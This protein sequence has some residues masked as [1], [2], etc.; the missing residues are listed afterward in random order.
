MKTTKKFLSL[1]VAVAALCGASAYAADLPVKAPYTA[2]VSLYNWTG[3]YIGADVGGAWASQDVT[4]VACAICNQFPASGTLKGSSLLGGVYAG[5]NFM[6][7]PQFLV[8]IEGDWNFAHLDDT[9]TAPSELTDGTP[10]VAGSSG[11]DW[12]H[13]VKW[14]AS[15][16]G[17]LGWAIMPNALL[18]AT[19]GAAWSKVDYS[20]LDRFG[21]GCPN[22]GGV[23]FSQ[24][25]TGYAV[26][27]GAEWAP[28]NNNWLVRAEYLYYHFAGASASG[29]DQGGTG[30]VAATFDWDDLSIHTARAGLAY[31]F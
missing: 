5:Y 16:R 12:S 1:G 19:G 31:R 13:D 26:G 27:A 20:A 29:I 30:I 4:S 3:F 6:L 14:L 2:P 7:T 24:T 23:S 15:I 28:W 21:N 25:K 17:R 11:I 10:D 22:C 8:G 18:Y 9:I